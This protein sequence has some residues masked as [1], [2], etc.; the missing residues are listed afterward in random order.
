MHSVVPR[1]NRRFLLTTW[2][3]KKS[4][5]NHLKYTKK[6]LK[7]FKSCL[8]QAHT[9]S[10]TGSKINRKTTKFSWFGSN[11]YTLPFKVYLLTN[12][13]PFSK[14]ILLFLAATKNSRTLR[15]KTSFIY[16]YW[17]ITLDDTRLNS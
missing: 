9:T 14:H 17:N 4:S 2:I 1:L 10:Y 6:L 16:L 8:Y 5:H 11:T 12:V 13:F 3:I 15:R 7:E